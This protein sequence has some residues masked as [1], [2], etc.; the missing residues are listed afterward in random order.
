VQAGLV[1]W[2]RRV[3]IA[4]GGSLLV[5]LLL[6]GMPPTH[7]SAAVPVFLGIT[8]VLLGLLLLAYAL[9]AFGLWAVL[10]WSARQVA[11]VALGAVWPYGAFVVVAWL[12]T[13]QREP[14]AASAPPVAGS[15]HGRR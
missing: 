8:G 2:F 11:F 13:Q 5:F 15:G 7:N 1:T 9:L 14:E 6:L 10:G 4:E 12:R 3:A